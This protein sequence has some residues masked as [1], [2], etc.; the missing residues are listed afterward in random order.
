MTDTPIAAPVP[1]AVPSN[2]LSYTW[3]YLLNAGLVLLSILSVVGNFVTTTSTIN[4]AW[5][6]LTDLQWHWA[7]LVFGAATA[8]NAGLAH[9]PPILNPPTA[10]RLDVESQVDTLRNTV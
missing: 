10:A 9:T 8:L 2:K 4:A 6:G 7:L 3:R 5:L 1:T